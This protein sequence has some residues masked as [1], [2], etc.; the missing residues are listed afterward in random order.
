MLNFNNFSGSKHYNLPV[1]PGLI[2]TA[3]TGFSMISNYVIATTTTKLKW[4]GKWK[5]L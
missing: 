5:R 1:K 4:K 2:G 3:R